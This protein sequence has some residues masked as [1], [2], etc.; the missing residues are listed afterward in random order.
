MPS[1]DSI[2]RTIRFCKEDVES[3]ENT[4]KAEGITF[5]AAVHRLISGERKGGTEVHPKNPEK[6]LASLNEIKEMVGV[7]GLTMEKTFEDIA[8]FMNN[9]D[10]TLTSN[11]LM[12]KLP[13]WAEEITETCRDC[14]IRVEEAMAKAAKALR[15]GII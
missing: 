15:K 14:G 9:G 8:Q 10:I 7:T 4:M 1:H 6:S 2:T 12:I 11:G 3:I 13:E 5:N